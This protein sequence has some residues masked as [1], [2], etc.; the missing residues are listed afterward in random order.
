VRCRTEASQERGPMEDTNLAG[1]G[2]VKGT[3]LCSRKDAVCS[4]CSNATFAP[5]PYR[6]GKGT[7]RMGVPSCRPAALVSDVGSRLASQPHGMLRHQA[8][9]RPCSSQRYDPES[10]SRGQPSERAIDGLSS[11]RFWPAD[12]MLDVLLPRSTAR[13]RRRCRFCA[14]GSSKYSLPHALSTGPP[15]QSVSGRLF[16]LCA[17]LPASKSFRRNSVTPLEHLHIV[18]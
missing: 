14:T 10:D 1:R 12:A 9:S 13:L 6:S 18:G 17:S 16:F 8:V 7:G 15:R 2:S 4:P 5:T 3:T 11:F